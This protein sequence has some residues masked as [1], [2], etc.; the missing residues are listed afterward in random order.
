MENMT[1]EEINKEIQKLEEQKIR[2]L[3]NRYE[4]KRKI[5]EEYIGKCFYHNIYD[6]TLPV[7]GFI[8]DLNING[9]FK[10]IELS[11]DANIPSLDGDNEAWRSLKELN[12]VTARE[13]MFMLD[14]RLQMIHDAW[15]K[16]VES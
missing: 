10:T 4:Q 1:I 2:L 9:D 8:V 6:G 11:Y 14:D 7:I 5:N 16:K 13:F 15:K 3:N 12:F